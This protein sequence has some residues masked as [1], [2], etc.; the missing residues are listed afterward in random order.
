MKRK[1]NADFYSRNKARFL[2]LFD[3]ITNRTG[4]VFENHFGGELSKDIIKDGRS[5]FDKILNELPYIGGFQNDHTWYLLSSTI[6]LSMH[7]AMKEHG[8]TTEESGQIVYE[9]TDALFKSL[10]GFLSRY[11]GKLFFH[12]Y[13]RR[14]LKQSKDTQEKT[15][16]YNWVFEVFKGDG[17]RYDFAV[18]YHECFICRFFKEQ[19]EEELIPYM[20]KLDYVISDT[21]DW[22]LV[23]TQTIYNGEK[24]CNFRYKKGRPAETGQPH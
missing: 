19:G 10:P 14:L 13:Y 7:R 23:R 8:K 12:I 16:P 20:C 6:L 9:I 21:F 18:D 2:K 4:P 11:G 22:G 17:V 3:F 15:Y 24:V 5:E 1:T